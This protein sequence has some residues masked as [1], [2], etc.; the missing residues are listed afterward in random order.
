M[1]TR[2]DVCNY[3]ENNWKYCIKENHEDKGTLIG[4]PHPYTVPAVG[5]FDEMYY[6]DTYFTNKGLEIAG[7]YTQV[8]SNTD[9]IL[10]LVNKFGYMPNGNRIGYLSRSQP[11]FLSL[12]VRDVWEYYHDKEWLQN[13]YTT[14]QKEYAFWTKQRITPIGLNRYGHVAGTSKEE[15]LEYRD[16]F[17]NRVGISLDASAESIGEHFMVNAESGWDVTPRFAFTG[18]DFAPVDLN[19]LLFAFETNMA[20]F[21]NILENGEQ[22]EW[23]TRAESRKQRMISFMENSEGVLVDYNFKEK[24]QSSIL[25]AASFYPLFVG[26]A[27]KKHAEAAVQNL[28]PRL[29]ADYGILTCEKNDAIGNYQWD[30]P[31]GWACLQYIAII[32][33]HRYGYKAEARRIAQKYVSLVEKIFA[34]TGNLWEKYNVVEGNINVSNE[35]KMPAMMGWSAGTYLA[36]LKYLNA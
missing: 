5:H 22:N 18:Q 28:L 8:K 23:A 33:L 36:A 32:G 30:Y 16:L 2:I 21:A 24:T 20:T 10:Y 6:W 26:M 3:I 12:M 35:Y 34:Q 7:N 31:N 27:E 15:I 29:E 25:S 11:P 17:I 1:S 4:L 13:A 19:T 9:N 14:L